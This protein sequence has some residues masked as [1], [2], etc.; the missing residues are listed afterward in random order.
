MVDALFSQGFTGG[1]TAS[2]YLGFCCLGV[3]PL[4]SAASV[5]ESEASALAGRS[6]LCD[7]VSHVDSEEALVAVGEPSSLLLADVT[8]EV[9]PAC[10]SALESTVRPWASSAAELE[11]CTSVPDNFA[12]E[13]P[14]AACAYEKDMAVESEISPLLF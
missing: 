5:F 8:L 10:A 14:W 3:S 6:E 4:A 12:A 11:G 2:R 7:L 9:S 13:R 1:G